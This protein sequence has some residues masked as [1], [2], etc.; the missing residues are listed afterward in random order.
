MM[1]LRWSIRLL[2][3]LFRSSSRDWLRFRLDGEA[4]ALPSHDA[5]FVNLASGEREQRRGRGCRWPLTFCRAL[6]CSDRPT[7]GQGGRPWRT[8]RPSGATS[9]ATHIC[10]Y[11][12]KG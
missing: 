9:P 10:E 6:C 8:P 12:T 2:G 5:L 11:V 7:E 3:S 1:E 4:G